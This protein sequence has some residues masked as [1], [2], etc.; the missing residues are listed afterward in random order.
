M[1]LNP[2]CIKC[3]AMALRDARAPRR[4]PDARAVHLGVRPGEPQLR[5]GPNQRLDALAPIEPPHEQERAVM[6]PLLA[7]GG[8][9]RGVRHDVRLAP[10][11]RVRAEQL[12]QGR[13]ARDDQRAAAREGAGQ[14]VVLRG[15]A[16]GA[17]DTARGHERQ[18]VHRRRH[19]HV[20][21]RGNGRH[22]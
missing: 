2:K 1:G 20:V 3:A 8:R 10:C 9:G 6:G 7:V 11:G 17:V 15:H 22:G 5:A 12:A 21:E 18:L 13:M 19:R 14:P 4:P 16:Q